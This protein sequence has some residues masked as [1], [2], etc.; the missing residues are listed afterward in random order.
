MHSPG[1]WQNA[2]HSEHTSLIKSSAGGSTAF[3]ALGFLLGPPK[4]QHSWLT[5]IYTHICRY[6]Y[7][8]LYA[9]IHTHTYTY[10]YIYKHPLFGVQSWGIQAIVMDTWEVQGFPVSPPTRRRGSSLATLNPKPH[11]LN[12]KPCCER[13][14]S[15][16]E[17]E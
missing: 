13:L 5:Y 3:R 6:I 10:I 14:W 11:T 12:P 4:Y 2:M 16:R 15:C 8:C 1:E 9:C 17:M 7:V